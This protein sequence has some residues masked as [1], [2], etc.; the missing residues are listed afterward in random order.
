MQ[1]GPKAQPTTRL[2]AAPRH[3]QRCERARRARFSPAVIIE[4]WPA[5]VGERLIAEALRIPGVPT[6]VI[7][8][9]LIAEMLF[10]AGI[11][12]RAIDERLVAEVLS[13]C[14]RQAP[15]RRGRARRAGR[16]LQFSYQW[17][18]STED[19]K[20]AYRVDRE[21]AHMVQHGQARRSSASSSPFTN[22]LTSCTACV[23]MRTLTR[24]DQPVHPPSCRRQF[25]QRPIRYIRPRQR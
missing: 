13:V 5:A 3:P 1:G 11:A 4:A 16:R 14:T 22:A 8:E 19:Q 15:A 23:P 17:L 20:I 2:D 7:A 12:V 24:G 25:R 21:P 9:R 18:L 6:V 10:V